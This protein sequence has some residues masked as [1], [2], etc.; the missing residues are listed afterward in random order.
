VTVER[1]VHII[2]FMGYLYMELKLLIR[3]HYWAWSCELYQSG[4]ICPSRRCTSLHSALRK[5][6]RQ[7]VF[8]VATPLQNC[9][10]RLGLVEAHLMLRVLNSFVLAKS[11]TLHLGFESE[12]RDSPGIVPAASA[13]FRA[14]FRD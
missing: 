9:K 5:L 12:P 8:I 1:R 4:L 2:I 10:V 3:G 13:E 11:H 7:N 14:L 6:T